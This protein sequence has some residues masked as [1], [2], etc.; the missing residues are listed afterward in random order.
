MKKT[1][2]HDQ[3][4]SLLLLTIVLI[5]CAFLWQAFNSFVLFK[6][7]ML[8]I[9]VSACTIWSLFHNKRISVPKWTVPVAFFA[10]YSVLSGL[11]SAQPLFAAVNGM[12]LFV[13]LMFGTLLSS[14]FDRNSKEHVREVLLYTTATVSLIGILQFFGNGFLSPT[15]TCP[16]NGVYSRRSATPASLPH[17]LSGFSLFRYNDI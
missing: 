17:S 11:Y 14:S 3:L 9:M 2:T 16:G 5:P 13:Y 7:L 8:N 12:M 15:R 6:Q 10:G 1:A 4:R